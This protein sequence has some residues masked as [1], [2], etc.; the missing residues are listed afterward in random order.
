MFQLSGVP[1][2]LLNIDDGALGNLIFWLWGFGVDASGLSS[3]SGT[4][5][6]HKHKHVIGDIPTLLG[7]K[8]VY[9]GYPYPYFCLCAFLGP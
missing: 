1:Y 2:I 7:F 3:L 4:P 9:M 5:K 8:G 6:A